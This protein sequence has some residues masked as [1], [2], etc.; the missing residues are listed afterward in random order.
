MCG[1]CYWGGPSE[2]KAG[3]PTRQRG[4]ENQTTRQHAPWAIK[5]VAG[6]AREFRGHTVSHP[7][8]WRLLLRASVRNISLGPK[9]DSNLFQ[10]RLHPNL[11]AI[12]GQPSARDRPRRLDLRHGDDEHPRT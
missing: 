4:T 6:L 12:P 10:P 5:N 7:E 3:N 11:Q 8:A 9:G 2:P 1:A